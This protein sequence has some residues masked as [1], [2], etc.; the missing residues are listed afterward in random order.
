MCAVKQ[1]SERK[2]AAYILA[3]GKSIRMGQDKGFVSIAGK[4][5]ILH[6]IELL[7][8][9]F[10]DIRIITNNQEYEIFG[11]KLIPDIIED[12]GPMGG[13]YTGLSHSEFDMSFFISCD[14]PFVSKDWLDLLISNSMKGKITVPNIAGSI[15]PL[16][17]I[18]PKNILP[19]LQQLL[20]QNKLKMIRMIESL[21]HSQVIFELSE[22]NLPFEFNNIN[23]MLELREVELEL[24]KINKN[25]NISIR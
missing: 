19:V 24:N 13:V 2:I 1:S 20:A 8:Q 4:P 17:A 3:G 15:Q 23:S 11:K 9:F 12:K 18:Y 16:F 25:E 22:K 7:E 14:M 6:V 10:S 5:M 21:P